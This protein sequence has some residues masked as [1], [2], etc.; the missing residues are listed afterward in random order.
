VADVVLPKWG[1]SM[2]EATI[3]LWHKA[4]GEQIAQGEAL[5]D[6]ETDKVET[7]I[8]SPA[9]GTLVEIL[10]PIGECVGVGTLLA[11]IQ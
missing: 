7:T 9:S 5:V 10:V 11:V 3:T 2:T 1:V 4:A 6:V 8:D